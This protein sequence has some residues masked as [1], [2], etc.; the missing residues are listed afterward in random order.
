MRRVI[1]DEPKIVRGLKWRQNHQGRGRQ[2]IKVHGRQGKIE[3]MKG[4]RLVARARTMAESK[5]FEA[6]FDLLM[7]ASSM[8]NPEAVYA[9]GT[10]Y[11]HGRYV[12]KDYVKSVEYLKVACRLNH[13]AACLDMAI[14][15]E[16]GEGVEKSTEKAFIYYQ[17]A[18]LWGNRD[19]LFEV[20]RCLYHGIGVEENKGLSQIWLDRYNSY[21]QELRFPERE[22][23]PVN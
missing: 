16:N 3:N 2:I 23:H 1:Q 14:C 19:A 12:E 5:N 6:A 4:E 8:S 20:Y 13:P 11:L 17:K 15:Y 9:I 7:R 22:A 21:Q 18:S 10:W